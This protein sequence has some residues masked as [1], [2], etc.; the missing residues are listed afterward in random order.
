M[1]RILT[2]TAP[3]LKHTFYDGETGATVA[4]VTVT[5]T[6]DDGTVLVTGAAAAVTGTEWSYTLPVAYTGQV[7]V[8]QV[9]WTATGGRAESDY[10]EV[11]GGFHVTLMQIRQLPDLSDQAKFTTDKLEQARMWWEDLS[12]EYCG[13]A[14]VPR[15]A[16][17]V[18]PAA[19]GPQWLSRLYPHVDAQ[20]RMLSR[21]YPRRILSATYNGTADTFSGW[22]VDVG[23]TVTR[24]TG[25]FGTSFRWVITYEHGYATCPPDIQQAGLDAIRWKL[26]ADKAGAP[27]RQLSIATD[28]GTTRFAVADE[29]RPTGIDTVDS[30]LARRR[31]KIPAVG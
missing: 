14:F 20:T 31:V 28:V 9:T 8:L 1:Q 5:V 26:L 24:D 19:G 13:V 10:V 17:D 18:F 25:T 12:E 4:G 27:S 2:N 7:D 16:K 15:Y 23:G 3:V 21:L 30:V 11:A 29:D 6:R 22:T